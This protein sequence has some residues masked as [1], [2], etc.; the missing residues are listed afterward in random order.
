MEWMHVKTVRLALTA[1]TALAAASVL[2]TASADARQGRQQS[3]QQA[4]PQPKKIE[5]NFPLGKNWIA[6]SLNG[7]RYSGA[8]RPSFVLDSQFRA[9]GFGGCN[10]FSAVAFPLRDMGIAV[11]PL[12]LTRR[13]CDKGSQG[14]ETA[15]LSALRYAQKW[16]IVNGQLVLKGPAGELRFDRTF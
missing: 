7:K 15:Y 16:D 10:T 5:K 12:A 9:R 14:A 2:T 1:V 8:E 3:Q 4:A 11:G 6:V 13:A